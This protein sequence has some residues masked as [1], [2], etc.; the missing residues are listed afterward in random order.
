MD[1]SQLQPGDLVTVKPNLDHAAWMVEVEADPR[2]G[3]GTRRVRDES[4]DQ[5]F[6]DL[7]VTKT[8][9]KRIRLSNS[10]WY[11]VE[12]GYQEHSSATLIE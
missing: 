7:V 6:A 10:F 8:S 12:D 5:V 4:V 3:G 9:P 2:D 1:L 11:L